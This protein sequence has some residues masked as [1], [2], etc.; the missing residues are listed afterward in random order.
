MYQFKVSDA[1]HIVEPLLSNTNLTAWVMGPIY[2]VSYAII[3]FVIE[4][5]KK[6]KKSI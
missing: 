2:A 4:L 6:K 5:V 1:F 3:L